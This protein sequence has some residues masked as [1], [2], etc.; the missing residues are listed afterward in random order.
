MMTPRN[1]DDRLAV[2]ATLVA[3]LILG[4]PMLLALIAAAIQS[5]LDCPVRLGETLPCRLGG[6]DIRPLLDALSLPMLLLQ[7]SWG[8]VQL[9]Q[10]AW[11]AIMI[12]WIARKLKQRKA[13]E[14][15]LVR[16]PV[17]AAILT[18]IIG[19][20]PMLSN[21]L[22]D[23]I[24]AKLG[25]YVNEHGAYTRGITDTYAGF[26]MAGKLDVGPLL[27]TM[28]MLIMAFLL[29]WP[30]LLIS[31]YLWFRIVMHRWRRRSA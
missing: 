10:L 26:C 15:G 3:F 21:I 6:T 11:L 25:C 2:R 28:H 22:A 16:L 13:E 9:V 17:W 5:A 8:F 30:I 27:H 24:A 20:G 12:Y 7:N 18:F 19:A 4:V 29:T 23:A 14:A 1:P 31:V